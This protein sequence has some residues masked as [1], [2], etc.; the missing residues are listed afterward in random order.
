LVSVGDSYRETGGSDVDRQKKKESFK[1]EAL[2]SW[3]AF[4]ETG[5]HLTGKEVHDWLNHWG[6][7]KAKAPPKT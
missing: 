6:T 1:Q 3:A 5:R 7:T 2:A 4:Q